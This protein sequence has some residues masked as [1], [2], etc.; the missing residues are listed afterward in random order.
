MYKAQSNEYF[1]CIAMIIDKDL[2]TLRNTASK[3][4][5]GHKCAMK[6]RNATESTKRAFY[7]NRQLPRTIEKM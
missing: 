7:V 1:R 3:K 6:I 2:Y 5:F 4:D